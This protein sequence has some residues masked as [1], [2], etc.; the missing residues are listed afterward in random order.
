MNRDRRRSQDLRRDPRHSVA[1][2]LGQRRKPGQNLDLLRNIR[3]GD[4]RRSVSRII[5]GQTDDLI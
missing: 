3:K 5:A 4:R 1:W 2:N